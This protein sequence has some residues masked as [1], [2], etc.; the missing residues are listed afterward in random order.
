MKKMTVISAIWAGWMMALPGA[1][2]A[3][4]V[5][6]V[7]Y[8]LPTTSHYGYAVSVLKVEVAKRTDGRYRLEEF[9]SGQLGGER[10]MVEG[11][12]LGTLDLVL[13]STGPITNF[14][15][16]VGILD[17]PF[18]FTDGAHAHRVLDGKIG[19]DL[20]AKFPSRGLI[21]L[22]W[23]D[24][25]FRHLT[26]SKRPVNTPEDAKGLKVRTME[27]PVHILAFKTLGANPTPMS[28]PEVFGALQQG[29]IDGQE[30]AIPGSAS[31]KMS[32]VQKHLS[33]TG[34]FF[35]PA[36]FIMSPKAFNALSPA[37]KQNFLDAA[38]AASMSLRE[39]M[40][41][42]DAKGVEQMKKE[43]MQVVY[44]IDKQK[45]QAAL[46]PA[47]DEYAKKYGQANIDAIRNA[48]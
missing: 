30:Q 6:K 48:K 29:T 35:S 22:S 18:L 37:D 3:Q 27:N 44:D 41:E 31:T 21:G 14:V 32:Q 24:Q 15:P 26:N 11:V 2:M 1:A 4:T 33:L 45:F 19:Q 17:I 36:V 47:Y 34:H 43:G 12:Q 16:D 39:Y 13:T 40:K 38:K 42:A 28:F 46:K 20:L 23:A 8:V 10:E 7:G 5:L 25:S 9:P